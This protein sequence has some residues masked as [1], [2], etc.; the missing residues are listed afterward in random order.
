[1]EHGIHFLGVGSVGKYVAYALMRLR[2]QNSHNT[3]GSPPLTLLFQQADRLQSWKDADCSIRYIVHPALRLAS[4]TKL[5]EDGSADGFR[6]EV[7]LQPPPAPGQGRGS[8]PKMPKMEAL[9][10]WV[11]SKASSAG[12][13]IVPASGPIKHLVVATKAT[14]TASAL[15]R[16][17]HRLDKDSHV[18]FLQNGLGMSDAVSAPKLECNVVK[19]GD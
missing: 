3:T 15:A 19:A 16:V 17:R 8:F 2:L 7:A 5:E 11:A 18:V 12:V 6:V 9:D 10:R 14:V 13:A 4:R 1:M